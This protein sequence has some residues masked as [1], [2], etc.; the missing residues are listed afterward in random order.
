MGV[1]RI[2]VVVYAFSLCPANQEDSATNAA[3]AAMSRQLSC[4][5]AIVSISFRVF[6]FAV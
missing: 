2:T 6:L 5:F 1:N 4:I 3:G